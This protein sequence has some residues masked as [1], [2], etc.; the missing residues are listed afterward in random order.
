VNE[1][2]KIAAYDNVIDLL[3]E[4]YG[5]ALKFD[6]HL[7]QQIQNV[8]IGAHAHI[9]SLKQFHGAFDDEEEIA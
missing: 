3:E 1:E 7:A 8:Q 6:R 9:V 5:A 4:A 2:Q